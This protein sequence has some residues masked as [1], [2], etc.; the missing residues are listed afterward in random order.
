MAS[1]TGTQKNNGNHE[2]G[3]EP[4]VIEASA[5]TSITKGE[6]DIQVSTA[7]RYPRD[8]ARFL[9]NAESLAT[10]DAETAASC[11]YSVPRDG[12]RIEGPSVRLAEIVAA[13]WGNLRCEA[14]IVDEGAA[15]ITAQGTAWDIENNVLMRMETRRRITG[16]NGRRYGDDMII[17]TGNAAA[18]IAFR[19]ALFKVVPTAV[20]K[21]LQERVR[22]V[23]LGDAATL[24]ARR[25]RALEWF[26]K[27]GVGVERV[28]A[29]LERDGVESINLEDLFT[30]Q[31]IRTAIMDGT[32]S[33]DEAFPTAAATTEPV[34]GTH[35]VGKA[36]KAETPAKPE[37]TT[38]SAEQPETKQPAKTAPAG[39]EKAGF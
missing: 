4:E 30:L 34:A 22:K 32:T 29:V 6:V 11:F 18:A 13:C 7:K 8:L 17:T 1:S 26:N 23:A 9:K 3:R 14:R 2:L 25:S 15:F 12:K 36:E 39:D 37:S 19:N 5:L 16:R 10:V 38:G 27:A 35:R 24:V 31:G 20:T 21:T 33:I 28:L